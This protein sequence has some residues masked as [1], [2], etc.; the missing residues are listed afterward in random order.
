MKD[1]QDASVLGY[2]RDLE[3][4][5]LERSKRRRLLDIVAI[6]V[7]AVMSGADSRV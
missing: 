4:P 7:C 2:F 1:G 5:R 6:A 3:K